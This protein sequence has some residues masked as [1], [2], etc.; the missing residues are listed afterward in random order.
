MSNPLKRNL[1]EPFWALIGLVTGWALLISQVRHHWGG[2]SYY[3]FGWFV[4]PLAVWLLARNLSKIRGDFRSFRTSVP[5]ELSGEIGTLG[6]SCLVLLPMLLF[7]A[8]SEV[9]P[10]W[11]VPL[12]AQGICLSIYT[13]LLLYR[14]Y[15]WAGVRAGVF[16]LVFLTTMIPWPFRMES[17]IV[18]SLTKVV[19][20]L[21]VHGLHFLS[22]PV[23]MAGNTL[24]LGDIDIGVDEACSG[25]R[26]LQALFMVTLFLGSLFGQTPFRRL[27]A[28]MVLPFIVIAVNTVRAVFLSI[29]LIVNGHPAYDAWHDTA[30]YIAFGVSMVVI[31]AAIE[32]LNLGGSDKPPPQEMDPKIILGHWKNSQSSTAAIGYL[33]LPLM[34]F[35]IVEGWFRF[36]ELRAPEQTR[37][38]I[39]LPDPSDPDYAYGEISQRVNGILG[40]SYG[41]RFTHFLFNQTYIDLYYYGYTDENK[42]SSVSSY[43]HSPTICMQ[44]NGAVLVE[45]IEP[46]F[47]EVADLRIPFRHYLFEQPQTGLKLHVFW[48]VWENRNMNISHEDLQ[49]LNYRTQWVQL[50]KGRRDFSRQVV[51]ASL[52][53]VDASAQARRE[54]R[55]LMGD[56]IRPSVQD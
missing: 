55:R 13:L 34:V 42:L 39:Q 9:N 10:F 27:L 8:L 44:G 56:W 17:L 41:H 3:N 50:R 14:H 4:P 33:L 19:V 38:E 30:G 35:S 24:R 45:E 46:M 12:W 11:R 23:E 40:Y 52:V 2:E 20:S 18:L 5:S 54:F 37:W 1:P 49:S 53:G 31:Y 22:Y 15:G 43:G 47:I 36:H 16:P 21:A 32:L 7:H 48:C 28:L 29:Q 26:S 6:A 51:L 25:I